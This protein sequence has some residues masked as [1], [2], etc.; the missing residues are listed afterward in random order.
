[1]FVIYSSNIEHENMSLIV[2]IVIL[3]AKAT[4]HCNREPEATEGNRHSKGMLYTNTP[5]V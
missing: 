3:Q 4:D 5:Y 1:M 2:P